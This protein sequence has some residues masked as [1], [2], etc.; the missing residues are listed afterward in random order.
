MPMRKSAP[1]DDARDAAHAA[2]DDD[3]GH[4]DRDEQVDAAREDRADQR[5]RRSRRRGRRT[6]PPG[7]TPAA[8]SGSGSRRPPRRRPRP[9]GSP[10]TPARCGQP[11][12]RN[13]TNATSAAKIKRDVVDLDRT[14]EEVRRRH[15][16]RL[17]DVDDPARAAEDRQ[18]QVRAG[19][20]ADDLAEAQRGDRQVVTADAEDRQSEERAERSARTASRTAAPPRRARR[21][22]RIRPS[23]V[24]RPTVYAPTAKKATKPRSSRPARPSVM[25]RP[26]PIRM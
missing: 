26:K 8:W 15:V 13:A 5:L 24:N 21:A 19:E 16:D 22:G 17:R 12:S 7:C 2:D 1:S 25:F 18:Q 10:P 14:G 9:R 4:V 23:D 11:R 20:D 3:R 6:R